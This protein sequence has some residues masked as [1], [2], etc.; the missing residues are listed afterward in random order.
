MSDEFNF[1]FIPCPHCGNK[2]D[3]R[4][5][6]FKE[7]NGSAIVI[8]CPKC[9]GKGEVSIVQLLKLVADEKKIDLWFNVLNE[10]DRHPVSHDIIFLLE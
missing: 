3:K 8:T 9:G 6:R 1:N 2:I 4:D 7:Y 5:K 10:R